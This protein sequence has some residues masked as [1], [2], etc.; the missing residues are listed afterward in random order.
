MN[1]LR[2]ILGCS[3]CKVS[4]SDRIDL[5]IQIQMRLR[6]IHSCISGT[7]D[8][9]IWLYF[10]CKSKNLLYIGDIKSAVNPYKTGI[11]YVR[12]DK[13]ILPISAKKLIDSD[14]KP[15][16]MIFFIR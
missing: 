9:G 4:R 1:E 16:T 6:S 13:M 5:V 3:D 2:L 11:R 7:V 8:D 14:T 10:L 12:V 15:V